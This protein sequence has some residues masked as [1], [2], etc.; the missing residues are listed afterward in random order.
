M[1]EN[2][3]CTF[4]VEF[5][6]ASSL[7]ACFTESEGMTADFGEV[8]KVSTSD[9]NGLSNKPQI[10]EVTLQGNKTFD[11]LGDHTLS[12]LEIKAI[13]DRIFNGGN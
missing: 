1:S 3:C 13:F 9:Y 4:Q 2:N 6:E 5:E 8:M 12:N 11:E 10:N 7:D